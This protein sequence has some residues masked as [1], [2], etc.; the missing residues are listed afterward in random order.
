MVPGSIIC[1][2]SYT[3]VRDSD[4]TEVM[5]A[6]FGATG[7]MACP[8]LSTTS[9]EAKQQWQILANTLNA[10]TPMRNRNSSSPCWPFEAV[11]IEKQMSHAFAAYEYA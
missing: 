10:S 3:P 6:G 7:F 8:M 2:L 9:S 1:P 11:G 4:A 5:I